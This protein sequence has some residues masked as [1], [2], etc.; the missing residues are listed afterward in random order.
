MINHKF[1]NVEQGNIEQCG[2]FYQK[3]LINEIQNQENEVKNLIEKA[4][5]ERLNDKIEE[6]YDILAKIGDTERNVMDNIPSLP[7]DSITNNDYNEI[8]RN[9]YYI[10][11]NIKSKNPFSYSVNPVKLKPAFHFSPEKSMTVTDHPSR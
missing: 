5:K 1:L 9:I 2:Y 6:I 7:L 4:N 8:K 3:E 11:D 10:K